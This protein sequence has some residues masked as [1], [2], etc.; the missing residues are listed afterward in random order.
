M[1][2][3]C[4]CGQCRGKRHGRARVCKAPG[5]AGVGVKPIRAC[6]E[7]R[8]PFVVV[9]PRRGSARHRMAPAFAGKAHDVLGASQMSSNVRPLCLGESLGHLHAQRPAASPSPLPCSPS[10]FVCLQNNHNTWSS[11]TTASC[12]LAV[13]ILPHRSQASGYHRFFG[14]VWSFVLP[15]HA[16]EAP[17]HS[18][19]APKRAR[20]KGD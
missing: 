9:P 11:A 10:Y 1:R 12:R 2:V 18:L 16:L 3:R 19:R 14:A 17:F 15:H 20:N 13:V 6:C 4:A 8:G 7:V 5:W